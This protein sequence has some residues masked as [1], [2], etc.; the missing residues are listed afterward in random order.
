MCGR[1]NIIAN[2]LT[3]LL[4]A[5]AGKSQGWPIKTEY[6][7]A[8]TQII[9]VLLYDDI[10]QSWDLR[11]MRWWLT[12]SWADGSAAR[13]NMFNAKSETLRSS[14]AYREPFKKRRCV[15]PTS[16]YYEWI[17][18][19][20]QKY[21]YYLTPAKE[22]GFAFAGLWD[23][24]HNKNLTIESC[25]IVTAAAPQ[26]M[27][28]FHHRIPV[29]LTV[30]QCHEWVRNGTQ[31]SELEEILRSEIRTDIHIARVSTLV[32]NARNKDER[33]VEVVGESFIIK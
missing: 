28:K 30:Q 14:R 16:G 19:G 18:E 7:I 26:P 31:L 15:I 6:N 33:C 12:P 4:I 11:Q 10:A 5:I 29:H 17:K 24:W 22:F 1:F 20:D 27:R 3:Q 21:P 2:S 9:P 23:S 13:Y 8:P 32:N 25:T